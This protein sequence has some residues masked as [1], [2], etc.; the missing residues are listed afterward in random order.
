MRSA[1][2]YRCATSV[3]YLGDS[4]LYHPL[5]IRLHVARTLAEFTLGT[6]GAPDY[7]D[8]SLVDGFNLPVAITNSQLYVLPLIS[9]ISFLTKPLAVHTQVVPLICMAPSFYPVNQLIQ[10]LCF[11]RNPNCPTSLAGP[12]DSSTGAVIGCKS[13]CTV[14]PN[15]GDSPSCCSG[16]HSTPAT[17]PPSGVPN[18]NYFS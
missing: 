11:H 1:H 8:V 7:Y 17:C 14:D 2:W 4:L 12:T 6:D 5:M 18:Y 3:R 15:P 16:S 10:T 9:S 13:D